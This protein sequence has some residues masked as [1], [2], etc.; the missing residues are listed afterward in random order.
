MQHSQQMNEGISPDAKFK[1]MQQIDNVEQEVVEAESGESGRKG[2]LQ[3]HESDARDN[4]TLRTNRSR[5][6]RLQLQD[7]LDRGAIDAGTLLV[8]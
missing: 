1:F 7:F 5:Y 6:R 3:R 2:I 4:K 8:H